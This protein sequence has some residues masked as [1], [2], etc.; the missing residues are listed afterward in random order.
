MIPPNGS[1]ISAKVPP[2]STPA[3]AQ[4]TIIRDAIYDATNRQIR[5]LDAI[6]GRLDDQHRTMRKIKGLVLGLWF[7]IVFPILMA[8]IIGSVMI[9]TAAQVAS[10]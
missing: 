5:H 8:V 10:R 4:A 7:V 6:I 9:I 1:R 2:I 3:T